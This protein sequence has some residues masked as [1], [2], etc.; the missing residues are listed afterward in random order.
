[1][2]YWEVLI[3]AV[4]L[5]MDAFAVS[6]LNGLTAKPSVKQNFAMAGSFGVAQMVFPLIGLLL[7]SAFYNLINN[8][9]HWIALGLL[10]ALGAKMLIDAKKN[11]DTCEVRLTAKMILIQ[12]V[13]TAIDALVVGVG[14]AAM[15]DNIP[16]TVLTI[17][18]VTFLLSLAGAFGGKLVGIRLCRGARVLGGLILIGIGVK[19]FV[20]HVFCG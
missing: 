1:M 10:A 11:P 12:A 18:A 2:Q 4:G 16:L 5:A 13:A 8:I 20:E 6:I 7:G 15:T 17:G 19:I 9:D 3:L 14:L